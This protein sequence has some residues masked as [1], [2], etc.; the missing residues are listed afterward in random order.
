MVLFLVVLKDFVHTVYY[1]DQYLAS[2]TGIVYFVSDRGKLGGAY[3]RNFMCA[4]AYMY[5]KI[6][7][8][9]LREYIINIDWIQLNS[10]QVD[11][12]ISQMCNMM[13]TSI[14]FNKIDKSVAM[15]DHNYGI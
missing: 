10:I 8:D 4:C 9:S 3:N 15:R 14:V 13:E 11:I 1:L 2:T 7:S 12:V 6:A 5:L